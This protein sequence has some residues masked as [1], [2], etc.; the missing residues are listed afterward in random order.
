MVLSDNAEYLLP[1]NHS[2]IGNP[3]SLVVL[4]IAGRLK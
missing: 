1:R 4:E 3:K 2:K